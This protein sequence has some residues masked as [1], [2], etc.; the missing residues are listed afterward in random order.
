MSWF[1]KQKDRL[2]SLNSDMSETMVHKKILRK[3]SDDLE[4][5][6][7][8]RCI[9][10]CSTENYINAIEDITTRSKIG[11]NWYKHPMDNKTSGKP[12]P[13]PNKPHYK[14]PLKVHKNE[15][16]LI[17]ILF[18][19]REAFA[20][21]N[22][23]LGAI[24]GHQVEI[25][26][27]VERPYPPLLRRPAYPGSPRA[28]EALESHIDEL[29]KLG[30][31]RKVGHNEEVEVETPVI[32]TW[33][34]DKSRMVGDFRAFNTYT[35]PDRYPIPR[36]YETFTQLSKARFITSTDALK[37][38]HQN[39]LTPQAT[40]LLSIISHCDTW[41][42]HLERLSLVL[43]KIHQVNIKISLKK[44]NFGFHELKALGHVVSG[45]SL[46]V[47]KNKVAAVLLKQMPQNKKEMMSFL[48]ISSYYR[49]HLRYFAIHARSLYR[50]CD[51]QAVFEMTQERIQAYEKIR[52][53]LTNAPFLLIPD[54]KLPFKMYIDACGEGLCAAL[55]QVQIVND[56]PYEGSI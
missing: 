40:K 10:P 41:K 34:N 2:T 44:C 38:F 12:I 17:E 5:A 25:M 24:K 45:Q 16:E 49:K 8:R 30:V 39:A 32:I 50:I 23:P 29:I 21:D 52:Y 3:C 31:L 53:A 19:Y 26:L 13:K 35:I 6:M 18:Q 43:K 14:A 20:S 11:R 46:G 47:D 4:H 48:G 37:G 27:N 36:I 56:K 28:R 42:L 22:E 1:L 7:R 9:D 55:H 51:Q 33:H 54:W 15:E